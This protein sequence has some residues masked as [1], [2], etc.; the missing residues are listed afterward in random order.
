MQETDHISTPAEQLEILY[1]DEDLIAINKPNGL[2]VHRSP[3]DRHETRFAIQLL[4]DQIGQYVYPAHRLDKPTSGV[5]L[6]GL[7]PQAAKELGELFSSHHI[8]KTY[9]AV[10]RGYCPTDGHIDHDLPEVRDSRITKSKPA[11]PQ[12]AI[13]DFQLLAQHQLK[14]EIETYPQSRYSLLALQPQTG[15][16]HQ[17]RRHLKHIS[18][19][20]IGDAKYGR[21]RHNRYFAEQLQC[22]RLLLHATQQR[23]LH[24]KTKK[25]ITINAPIDPCFSSLMTRFNWQHVLPDEWQHQKVTKL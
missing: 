21:G 6:F 9:L 19:P 17:L 15:R 12:A 18:H 11:A 3:I 2:L 13:T 22:P 1:Q 7:N 16:R 20:I 10:V 8:V 5:L 14:A 24:P 4:R 23:F 25:N